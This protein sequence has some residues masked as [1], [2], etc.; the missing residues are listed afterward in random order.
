MKKSR[1]YTALLSLSLTATT[2]VACGVDLETSDNGDL[3]GLWH[4]TAVDTI[5]TGG[6]KD[7][8][9]TKLFWAFQKD[10]L[11]IHD[12][13]SMKYHY[14]LRFHHA[15]ALLLVNQPHFYDRLNPQ[16]DVPM[17]DST[18]LKPFG[19]N[20]LEE[21]FTVLHLGSGSMMLSTDSLIISFKKL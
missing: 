8:S 21:R 15:G 7:L 17:T 20:H 2:F 16:G 10:L 14:L 5:A 4:M 18:E 11:D 19:I 3:D 12:A 9:K 1:L 13:D 6:V